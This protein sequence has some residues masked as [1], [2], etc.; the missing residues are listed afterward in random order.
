VSP[1]ALRTLIAIVFLVHGV[2]H[3]MGILPAVGLIKSKTWHS[4][5]WLF[6]R[7]LGDAGG[8][9]ISVVTWLVAAVG[10]IAA[11]LGLLG[12]LVPPEP[13]RTLAVVSA[14]V[15]LLGLVFFW[16]AFASFFPNKVGAIAVDVA[17]LVAILWAHWP[18]E[19]VLGS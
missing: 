11:G 7:I 10:F 2:G 16:N 1:Q 5:S 3:V 13:W 6:T 18:P 15:S 8:R 12:W 17:T 9:A 4:R 19:A 14:I